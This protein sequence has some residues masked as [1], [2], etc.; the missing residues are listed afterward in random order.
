MKLWAFL[1]AWRFGCPSEMKRCTSTLHILLPNFQIICNICPH[2]ISS[3]IQSS[4]RSLLQPP[5]SSLCNLLLHLC[6]PQLATSL[7]QRNVCVDQLASTC[8]CNV[9][10]VW[11]GR[12]NYFSAPGDASLGAS[13][14]PDKLLNFT[15]LADTRLSTFQP[16]AAESSYHP[17]DRRAAGHPGCCINLVFLGSRQINSSTDTES[18]PPGSPCRRDEPS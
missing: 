5:S 6:L 16:E 17:P 8:L 10:A 1:D 7:H 18:S 14:S 15:D 9:W 3:S 2:I 13:M 12:Y 4:L 11:K